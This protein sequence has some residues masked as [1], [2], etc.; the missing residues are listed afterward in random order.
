MQFAMPF[1]R[2]YRP[3]SIRFNCFCSTRWEFL[4]MHTKVRI[5]SSRL[6]PAFDRGQH[7]AFA[8]LIAKKGFFSCGKVFLLK[9]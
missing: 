5:L 1:C 8:L 9:R 2:V 6:Y 3:N 4:S 7:A